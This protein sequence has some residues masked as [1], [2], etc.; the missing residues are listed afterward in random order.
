MYQTSSDLRAFY[1][2]IRA[3]LACQSL[4]QLWKL[5]RPHCVTKLGAKILSLIIEGLKG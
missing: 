1:C 3:E 2:D 4:S 5:E